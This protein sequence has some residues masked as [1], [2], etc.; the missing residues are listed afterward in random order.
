M[1]IRSPIKP[2]QDAIYER[3]HADRPSLVVQSSAPGINQAP[4]FVL[5]GIRSSV[6]LSSR[7]S[8]DHQVWRCVYQIDLWDKGDSNEQIQEMVAQVLYA[9]SRE[10]LAVA[11]DFEQVG[12]FEVESFGVAAIDGG[13]EGT[14]QNGTITAIF[15][16]RDLR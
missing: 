1:T 7:S 12:D 4:P 9:L 14:F 8:I 3:I 10:K 15:E 6:D 11:D 5:I 16:I 13:S 2:L